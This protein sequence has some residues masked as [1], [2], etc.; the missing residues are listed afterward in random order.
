MLGKQF[1]SRAQR[2]PGAAS[3]NGA[4]QAKWPRPLSQA[5][6]CA[7]ILPNPTARNVE[8]PGRGLKPPSQAKAR[9]TLGTVVLAA[10]SLGSLLAQDPAAPAPE[11]Q[12]KQRAPRTPRPG[13]STPGVRR[14]MSS[15]KP[16]AVFITEGSPD[17]QVSTEDAEWVSNAPKNTVHRLDP[18]TNTVTAVIAVGKRPCSG[19]AAGFGSIWV[20]NCGD[21]TVSRIDIR[22]NQVVATIAAPPAASEGG[23]AASLEGVWLVT[24][25]KGILSKIDPATNAVVA[26]VAVPPNSAGVTYG[27][28]A[29]WVTSPDSNMLTGVDTKTNRV[30]HSLEVGPRPRFVTTGAGSV[31]TLNQGD[32][33]VSRV[34]AGTGKLIANI[35]VG[36]PGTGGEI[37]FGEGHVWATVFE[38]PISEIDPVTNRVVKQWFGPG[39]DSVRVAHGSVWL[40]NLRDGNVWRLSPNQP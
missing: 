29:V 37:A 39:G 10:W 30:I 26:E 24:D 8:T 17:W 21:K 34:D 28:G 1:L 38:I 40:S 25:V 18:K 12:K 13:V 14:E 15:I 11:G 20:P 23:I 36:V 22:T 27:E 35:E 33:T 2:P 3:E 19:L 9:S 6:A 16:E 32:G 5:K 31:W 7:T 4:T